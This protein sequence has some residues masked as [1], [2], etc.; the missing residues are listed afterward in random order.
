MKPT[1]PVIVFDVI[2][3]IFSLD[4]LSRSFDRLDLPAHTKD[5]FFAQLLRDAFATSATGAYVPFVEM[6][7]GTLHVLLVNLGVSAPASKIEQILPVFGQLDAHS[8]VQDA[9]ALAKS[10]DLEV[11]FFTN[12]SQKNT[13]SLIARNALENLVDHVV[14]IDTFSQWKP[15][16]EVYLGAI[17]AV[18]GKPERSAMIAAHAWDTQG[19]M[20]AGMGAGWVRRQ[21]S[22]FHPAM[23]P[24]DYSASDLTTLVDQVSV[25]LLNAA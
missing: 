10:R 6:A 20:N 18:G 21:D 19:A 15:Y 9:L 24:P 17:A 4:A 12:G 11:L 23:T 25:G 1:K 5:L 8:D 14:S 3:T 7:K 16:R 13:E 2:E 22:V